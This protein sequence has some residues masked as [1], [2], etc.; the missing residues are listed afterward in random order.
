MEGRMSIGNA[1]LII[2]GA[3]GL[4]LAAVGLLA[5]LAVC[6]LLH[7]GRR[8]RRA[9]QIHLQHA[10]QAFANRPKAQIT[11]VGA[12]VRL[13]NG[14]NALDGWSF[15]LTQPVPPCSRGPD[16]EWLLYGYTTRE[17]EEIARQP[18]EFNL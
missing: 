2:A 1:L 7:R 9:Q 12:L 18:E 15:H 17:L 5:G 16:G 4:T 8:M 13:P 6:F 11:K 10:R 14:L 3:L